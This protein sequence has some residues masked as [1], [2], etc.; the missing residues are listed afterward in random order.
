MQ[1]QVLLV[2]DSQSDAMMLRDALEERGIEWDVTRAKDGPSALAALEG[3]LPDLMVLDLS[4]PGMRGDEVLT[5][6]RAHAA[7]AALRVVVLTGTPNPREERRCR[8]L[9]ATD[10][11]VKPNLPDGYLALADSLR[12]HLL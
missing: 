5:R 10:F 8:A 6:V 7:T 4:L 12:E 3:A 1:P 11:F 2:E 9:G